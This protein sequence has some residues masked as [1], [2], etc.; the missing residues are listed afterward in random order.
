MG[1]EGSS[2]IGARTFHQPTK[3]SRLVD[4]QDPVRFLSQRQLL[5][6]IFELASKVSRIGSEEPVS[7]NGTDGG[8][9]SAN[10]S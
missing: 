6:I 10:K 2:D 3:Q 8:H 9:P 7:V 4:N 5:V 1:V